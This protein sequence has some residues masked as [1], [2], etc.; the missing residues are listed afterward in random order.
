MIDTYDLIQWQVRN[1]IY[2]LKR[3][4]G[5]QIEVLGLAENYLLKYIYAARQWDM[6]CNGNYTTLYNGYTG[7][8]CGD[9]CVIQALNQNR[10]QFEKIVVNQSTSFFKQYA[11]DENLSFRAL[12]QAARQISGMTC[13]PKGCGDQIVADTLRFCDGLPAGWHKKDVLAYINAKVKDACG[14]R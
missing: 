11:E 10:R 4:T 9:Y 7:T 6:V 8:Q 14:G 13:V 1:G 2:G 3:Y 12:N 5:T